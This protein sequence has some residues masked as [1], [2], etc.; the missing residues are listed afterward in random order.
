VELSRNRFRDFLNG[1]KMT[2]SYRRRFKT[3]AN[4][5]LICEMSVQ[6]IRSVSPS[7][8]FILLASVDV[9]KQVTEA[10]GRGDTARW[11]EASFRSLPE[12][13]IVLDSLGRIRHLN[14]AAERILGWSEAEAAGS[15]AEDLIPWRDLHLPDGTPSDYEFQSGVSRGWSGSAT[16][17]VKG[18]IPRQVRISTEP[19]V[20]ANGLVLGIVSCISPLRLSS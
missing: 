10:R 19:V 5:Y 7:S 11:L 12:A 1:M 16:V 6:V 17:I 18:G 14:H 3:Q 4:E 15:I 20:D 13:T 9:T 2:N 8:T